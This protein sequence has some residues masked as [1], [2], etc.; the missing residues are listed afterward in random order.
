MV[1]SFHNSSAVESVT[2]NH[3]V[4]G[5][6][7]GCGVTNYGINNPSDT[8]ST[9][10]IVTIYY[11]LQKKTN[12]KILALAAALPLM[13]APYIESKTSFIFFDGMFNT[14]QT[15]FLVGHGNHEPNSE[16]SHPDH[17]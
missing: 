6:N 13:A 9:T 16:E 2:V 12:M 11:S 10:H 3:F 7:P 1:I 4:P 15:E 8:T 5:S 14:S 17:T